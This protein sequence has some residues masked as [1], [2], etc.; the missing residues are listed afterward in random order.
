[1]GIR[2]PNSFAKQVGIVGGTEIEM[3]LRAD[4]IVIFKPKI[5]LDDLLKKV[6]KENLHKETDTGSPK[7]KEE[8]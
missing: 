6:T 3:N 5:T 8:W 4:E 1:M 2:I 7:G